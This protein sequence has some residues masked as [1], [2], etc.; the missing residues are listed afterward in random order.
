MSD[1]LGPRLKKQ[2]RNY[3][4]F[5]MHLCIKLINEANGFLPSRFCA[6]KENFKFDHS[7]DCHYVTCSGNERLKTGAMYGLAL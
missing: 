1:K 7:N 3:V 6:Y 2:V 5:R 4:G